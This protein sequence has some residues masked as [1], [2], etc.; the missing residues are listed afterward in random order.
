M[1]DSS[2]TSAWQSKIQLEDFVDAVTRGV[3]RAIEAQQAEVSGY[4]YQPG[5]GA[6]AAPAPQAT[7]RPGPI[8]IGIIYTPPWD[9]P[10][11]GGGGKL[12]TAQ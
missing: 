1:A 7:F 6:P 2:S 11:G 5:G 10:F 3:V 8:V 4:V 12:P 9:Q